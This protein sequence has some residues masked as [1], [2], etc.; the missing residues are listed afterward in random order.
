MDSDN[1]VLDD[2]CVSTCENLNNGHVYEFI[3]RIG[4]S[5]T[6]AELM[7]FERCPVGLSSSAF[8][9]PLAA[10]KTRFAKLR[11]NSYRPGP[12]AD[13]FHAF[14]SAAY[15]FPS[16]ARIS[17]PAPA[18]GQN[19]SQ[20]EAAQLGDAETFAK[21]ALEVGAEL[22]ETKETLQEIQQK[23][24]RKIDDLKEQVSE[25][26]VENRSLNDCLFQKNEEYKRLG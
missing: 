11:K 26:K 25:A 18:K 17:T 16:P 22:N 6:A 10:L 23:S 5:K 20:R 1:S 2:F 3:S 12:E 13:T 14:T 8:Q 19:V 24:K 21:V 7:S 4:V 15:E 9:Y